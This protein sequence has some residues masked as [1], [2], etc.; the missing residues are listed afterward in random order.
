[1]T[2]IGGGEKVHL[3]RTPFGGRKKNHLKCAPIGG[4][5]LSLE[6]TPIGDGKKKII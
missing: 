2:P 6:V 1:V 4:E 5:N 3:K